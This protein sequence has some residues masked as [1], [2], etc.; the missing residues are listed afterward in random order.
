MARPYPRQHSR[1]WFLGR[2]PYRIFILRE[3]SSVFIAAYT[4]LLLVLVQVVHDGRKAFEDYV[5]VLQSPALILFHAVAV[6]FALL[7]SVTWFQAVPK[8]VR[9]FRGEDRVP[10]QVLIGVHVAAWIG[11]SMV[12][13]IIFLRS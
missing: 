1:T 9:L 6:A 12:V 4:V 11:V 10:P 5:E 13:A 8:A 7:H 3:V 2:W